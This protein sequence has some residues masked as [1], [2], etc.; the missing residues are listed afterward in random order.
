[1]LDWNMACGFKMSATAG[2]KTRLF[3]FL[4]LFEVGTHRALPTK[5][6]SLV[7]RDINTIVWP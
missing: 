4:C 2:S 6:E 1:M 5:S 7:A 3:E